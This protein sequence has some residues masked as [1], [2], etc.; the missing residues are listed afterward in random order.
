MSTMSTTGAVARRRDRFEEARV[1]DFAFASFAS[2]GFGDL[3]VF[4]VFDVLD[5]LDE[6]DVFVLDRPSAAAVD[7]ASAFSAAAFSAA[8]FS[9]AAASAAAAFTA[10]RRSALASALA[11]A[12]AA[13]AASSAL[14][15]SALSAS[16]LFASAFAASAFAASAFARLRLAFSARFASAASRSSPHWSS[17]ERVKSSRNTSLPGLRAPPS[18]AASGRFGDARGSAPSPRNVS[19]AASPSAASGYPTS[20]FRRRPPPPPSRGRL[21]VRLSSP[22]RTRASPPRGPSSIEGSALPSASNTRPSPAS[23]TIAYS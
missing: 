6:L 10:A 18:A 4:D 8:A 23:S 2:A 9:A 3:D 20:A 5:V 11:F 21:G 17:K 1:E 13:R 16:A 19:D 14:S 15:A 7:R 12:L 22:N